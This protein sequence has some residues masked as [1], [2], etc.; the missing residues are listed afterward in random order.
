MEQLEQSKDDQPFQHQ[1]R[2]DR[3]I[4]W[5]SRTLC[6][7]LTY[8]VRRGLLKGMKRKGGL[9]WLPEWLLGD[10]ET[11]EHKFFRELDLTG[12]IVFDVGAFEGLVALFFAQHARQVVCYEP[13]A[14]NYDRLKENLQ[15]NH[16]GN[17]TVRQFG[18]GSMPGS[19]DMVWDPSRAGSSTIG[20]TS[21]ASTIAARKSAHHERIEITT[22]DIEVFENGLPLPEFIKIDIEGYELPALQGARRLLQTAHPTLYVEMH[23]ETM[24]EKRR[25]AKAVLEFLAECGYRSIIHVE[26]GQ[27]VGAGNSEVAAQGHLYARQK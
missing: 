2:K 17:V 8:T 20:S 13:N 12:K 21:M 3:V 9:A 24:N 23:G 4:S 16:I 22:L 11:R 27:A 5:T 6:D 15:L 26:T 10:G 14:R 7:H 1:S 19:S 25:N 18:V